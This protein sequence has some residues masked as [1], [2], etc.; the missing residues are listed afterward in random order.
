MNEFKFRLS[1]IF[2]EIRDA[3]YVVYVPG[4]SRMDVISDATGRPINA[5][6]YDWLSFT[7]KK[8]MWS[9]H[10]ITK[11]LS[12]VQRR[13][14]DHYTQRVVNGAVP[15]SSAASVKPTSLAVSKHGWVI[16]SLVEGVLSLS[17][18]PKI[19]TSEDSVNAE[20]VRLAKVNPGTQFFKMKI[21]SKVY[22]PVA[23]PVWE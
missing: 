4:S 10:R 6:N 7:P 1:E 18:A 22:V 11:K 9:T 20:I 23:N 19:H 2:P 21:E 8:K 14:R 16:G 12:D 13:V 15:I 17:K 5:S 3:Y